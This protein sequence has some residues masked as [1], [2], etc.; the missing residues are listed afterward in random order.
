[1]VLRLKTRESKSPPVLI[2]NLGNVSF[3]TLSG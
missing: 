1:M 3:K 2:G